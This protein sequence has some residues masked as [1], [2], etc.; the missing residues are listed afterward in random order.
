MRFAVWLAGAVVCLFALGAVL[1]LPP[2]WLG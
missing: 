2:Q 1:L